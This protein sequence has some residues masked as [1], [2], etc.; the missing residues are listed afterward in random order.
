[1]QLSSTAATEATTDDYGGAMCNST[2]VLDVAAGAVESSTSSN[3]GE[4]TWRGAP[5]NPAAELR[6]GQ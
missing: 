6:D 4:W 2:G 1:M 5:L 3:A